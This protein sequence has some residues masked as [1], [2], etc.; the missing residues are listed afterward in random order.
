MDHSSW[1]STVIISRA[2]A[3]LGTSHALSTPETAWPAQA[4]SRADLSALLVF[5]LHVARQ[6]SARNCAAGAQGERNQN[7]S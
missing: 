7:H 5:D 6:I 4:D 3:A 1:P 2:T